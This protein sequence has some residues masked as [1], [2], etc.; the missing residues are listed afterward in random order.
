MTQTDRD[1]L[2][3]FTAFFALMLIYAL[4]GAWWVALLQFVILSIF[5]YGQWG[6]R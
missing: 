3:G 2:V 5:V 1:G 6:T 4:T